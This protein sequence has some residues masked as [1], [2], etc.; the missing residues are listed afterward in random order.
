MKKILFASSEAHPLIKTG[1]LAD[2]SGSLPHA[3]SLL[4][5]D[6]C[7]ILPKYQAIHT[8]QPVYYKSTLYL[9][10][11]EVHLLETQ[12]PDSSVRVWLVDCPAL[13][14]LPGNPYTDALGQEWANNAERFALFCRVV[15][16]VAMDRAYLAWTPDLVHCNDWQTGLVPALL[17]LE[18]NRPA[19]VFTIHN[20]AYQGLYPKTTWDALKLPPSLWHLQGL[21]FN[22][23]FSFI[24]GGLVYADRI[25]TVS[26]TYADEIQTAELGYGLQGLLSHR[27]A[28]LIGIINGI[29]ANIWDPA[30][31]AAITTSYDSKHLSQKQ[32]N[33]RALQQRH[34]LPEHKSIPV[35]TLISRLVEQKGIDLLIAC[36]PELLDLPIQ[37]AILGSGDAGLEQQLLQFARDYPDKMAVTLGYDEALAHQ[38]E[39]GAD[40]FLMPSRFEPC[41]L[42]QLY[43]QRY[44]TV[45]IVRHTGGLA[46]TVTDCSA[47]T[48]ANKT[49]TGFVFQQARAG[50]LL[51]AC[52]RALWVYSQPKAWQQ[53]QRT[54]MQKDFSWLSSA[55][56]YQLLYGQLVGD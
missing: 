18:N 3:L 6:V 43:S 37:I 29:D 31:D 2:V 45:P 16:E 5:E 8:P 53:L 9:G 4:G 46:D 38:L 23:M 13:F 49:A 48:L 1:G 17:S 52:K 30:T 7:L 10:S 26:P 21:E 35:F 51:E 15:V 39:A 33:K 28:A 24:K 34:G 19:S 44:G 22:G 56:A 14:A 32:H 27:N 42:N 12:L 20:L 40:L 55:K 25:T 50:A 11:Y 54:G 36:L 41:G 47:E